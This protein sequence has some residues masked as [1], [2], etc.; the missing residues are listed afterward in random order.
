MS[1]PTS[2]GLYAAKF[3]REKFALNSIFIITL[4]HNLINA[5]SKAA[6]K[7]LYKRQR[8]ILI[9]LFIKTEGLLF[10][11][12]ARKDSAQNGTWRITVWGILG[13]GKLKILVKIFRPYLC[14]SC[15]NRF[16][17]WSTL[18][19]HKSQCTSVPV[20]E[21]FFKSTYNKSSTSFLKGAKLR[22]VTGRVCDYKVSFINYLTAN[23]HCSHLKMFCIQN[24]KTKSP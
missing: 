6:A 10:A 9:C 5:Q 1:T 22:R 19:K 12:S 15:G 4:E 3:L 8:L 11:Q 7:H 24:W 18:N 20:L 21:S 2:E 16:N 17:H 14:D 23:S 13:Q